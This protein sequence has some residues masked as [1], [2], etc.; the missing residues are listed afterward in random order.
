MTRRSWTPVA[1]LVACVLAAASLVYSS[2]VGPLA[3]ASAATVNLG[4]VQGQMA[5]HVGVD[6]G[7]TGNCI[8]YSPANT[9]SSSGVV[10]S[11]NEAITA[12]GRPG[13]NTST[14]PATLSTSS[15]SSVGF[16]PSSLTSVNDGAPFLIGRMIHYNNPVYAD[17]RYFTG[18]LRSTLTGF[19][20]PNVLTFNWTLDETP[21][22]GGNNCCNDTISFTNQI[23]NVTLSQGGLNFKL[24]ILGFIGT[25]TAATCPATPTG[26]PQNVFS[27]VEG[28]QTHACLY[29]S[30]VQ[31]RSLTIVKNVVGTPPGSPSFAFTSTSA[32]NGS[33]WSSS[34]FSLAGGGSVTRSVTSGDTVTV[35]ETDPGDDRWSLSS[36]VCRQFNAAGQLV[37]IPGSTNAAA[38]KVTL[39]NVPP[40]EFPADPSITCT[41]TNTYTPRSTL[42]LVKQVQGGVVS[43]ALW[44]LT[45]TG[46]TGATQDTV[47]SGPSGSDAVSNKRIVAGAYQLSEQGTGAAETG[48]VQVGNWTCTAGATSFPVTAEG[49][50]TLPDLP[51]GTIVT[52]AVVNRQSTGSLRISKVVDDPLGGYTG[53]T[54]KTFSGTYDCGAGASGTFS[55]LTTA[56]PV[57]I[58]GIPSGRVCSVSE[59][60]PTGGLLNASFAWGAPDYSTQPVTIADQQTA[61]VTVTNRVEQL[62]GAFSV[63]KAVDGPGGYSGGSDRVFPVSYTC[64][65]TNGPTSSGTL[66]VTTAAAVSPGSPIPAGSVCTFSESLTS[67][68]GDFSDPS[69]A[70]TGSSIA[71]ASITVGVDATAAVTVTNTYARETGEL[72]IA[73]VVDG[74]GFI[75]A[76]EPFVVLYDCGVAQGQVTLAAGGSVS[77]T[78]PA[79]TPCTVQEQTP[80]PAL[81]SPAF[82]WGT[83][84]WSPGITAIVPAGG[85]ATLTVTNPTIAVFGAVQVTKSIS[86][87]TAGVTGEASFDVSFSCDNGYTATFPVGVGGTA[88]TADLPVGTTCDVSEAAPSGGL[89]DASYAWGTPDVSPSSVTI[90]AAGQVVPVSIDNPVVRITGALTIAKTL[91]DPDGVVDPART[92][93]I[94]YSCVYGADAPVTGTVSLPPGG[95]QTVSGLLL[96]SSCAVTE[97]DATL[98]ARPSADDA[99][100]V[101]LPAS[102]DPGTSVIVASAA[103]PAEVTVTNTVDRLEGSVRLTKSV[104]GAGKD[105]GYDGGSFTFSVVCT[106]GGVTLLD[107]TPALADGE[108]W[109]P[110][111]AVDL[112]L[113][114]TCAIA[115]TAKPDPT[116]AA[117]G[118]DPV[119]FRIGGALE[120]GIGAEFV[121]DDATIPVQ[122]NATN[123]ITPR[124][125]SVT[126]AKQV[127]G[128]TDG[129]VSDAGFVVNLNC[130]PGLVYQVTVPSNG[131]ATQDGIPVGSTC[132]AVEAPPDPSQLVDASFSWGTPVYV[133]AD[134]T[135]EVPVDGAATV[136]VQNPIERVLVPLRLIKTLSGAQGIIDPSRQY[137]VTWSCTYGGTSFGG[138]V[139]V[140]ADGTGIELAND[141]PVTADCSATEGDAGDPSPDPAFR[142]LDPVIT[143]ATVTA[144]GPNVVTVANTLVRD[145]GT[146]LVRKRV[147]GAIEGYVNL[148]GGDED[149]TLHGSCSVPASP[150]IATR[151]AD[152]VIADGGEV[153]ITAS[154]GWT[155][156]GREDTPSND[157][158]V[159]SSYAW[160]EPVLTWGPISDSEPPAPTPEN[161][162]PFVLTREQPTIAFWAVNPIERVSGA[163]QISKV[164]SD[165]F[166]AVDPDATFTGSYSC[167][168]GT[169]AP[170]T[171]VWSLE[172]GE[173]FT[174]PD[175]LLESVC[176]VTEDDLDAVGLPDPSFEWLPPVVSGPAVVVAGGTATVTVTNTVGRLYAGLDIAKTLQD[177]DGGVLPGAEFTG[178]WTCTL[179]DL[180]L[181]DRFGVAANAT[182]AAFAPADERVPASSTCTLTE[183][184]PDP[185]D[186]VDGSFQWNAPAYDPDEVQLTAGETGLLTV[187]NS[188]S[189]VYSNVRVAKLLSGPGRDLVDPDR[190]FT[191]TVTCV[192]GT[193]DPVVSTWQATPATIWE[194]GGILVGS[195]CTATEDLP[196]AEGQPVEGDPS[197]AW[198]D[199][200]LGG[201]VIVTRTNRALPVAQLA[202][203]IEVTNP[204]RRVFGRFFL[205]KQVAGEV[206]GI[207]DRT[208]SY[209]MTWECVPGTGDPLGGDFALA[210]GQRI[211][212]GP[213]NDPPDEIP[214]GS[215]CTLTEP[216][217]TMPELIDDAWHWNSPQFTVEGLSSEPE[218]VTAPC[219]GTTLP[220]LGA[221]AVVIVVPHPQ[222]NVPDPTIGMEIINTVDQT[223]GAFT[224][225]KTSDPPTGSTIEPG[226]TITYTVTVDSTGTVP[227]H[228]V[229]IT[230]DLTQVLRYGVVAP[231]TAPAGTTATVDE[232]A[233]TLVWTVG[234]LAVGESVTLTYR[235]TVGET[236][237]DATIHNV[238]TAV[239][240]VPPSTCADPF[241]SACTTE[242][243]TPPEPAVPSGPLPP[244]GGTVPLGSLWAGG[245]LLALGAAAVLFTRRRARSRRDPLP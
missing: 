243:A 10:A 80:D 111:D 77:V 191:G 106:L 185:V 51:A 75:G 98:A 192:H 136:Q 13:Q 222:E 73:K 78:V 178:I 85:S 228:D 227:V 139:S 143:G 28:T 14:C 90:T 20:S 124:T 203:P 66:S 135:V 137:P 110:P 87:E 115:E 181:S 104:V 245:L 131:S 183:D 188:V 149:F 47:I 8:R 152:G 30:I 171:G 238:V 95:S 182:V 7:T 221:R 114:T 159:D 5:N 74:E 231:I 179:G 92:F 195:V 214:I 146:V 119:Q 128:L 207:V 32:L 45:A 65:L 16:R 148:G 205:T 209:P 117:F 94:D 48:F 187:S 68:S 50:V 141:V 56:A 63:I 226:E 208:Q 84:V 206:D 116:S 186:L 100:Y 199:P 224:V 24:V 88:S 142:W 173:T 3:S 29:A 81:L 76:G 230:D 147:T 70:W 82:A 151:Y 36:L 163:F 112:P 12:H 99:S 167:V 35:T 212:V 130:G 113:G 122:V 213:E 201:P 153:P 72:I 103:T 166:G 150:D 121:L 67:Q 27:T 232:S 61:T 177:P 197:Y 164:V 154:I 43:P 162:G 144:T 6:N 170:V 156:S 210:E 223:A 97:G 25:G 217:N 60:P 4:T 109:T 165:P 42:T 184:T 129:L 44:T 38:R 234:T 71:P 40:P 89:I 33:P 91:V 225:R 215:I 134:A 236:A 180:V 145:S 240:D 118:W 198:E 175:V 241:D 190:T 1:M 229:V 123:P 41:F 69:F 83:P 17:D 169:D 242:H 237:W 158:L 174:G 219:E 138:T 55:T 34:S 233:S 21:N 140:V 157:L 107:E 23:S 93:D 15:Q 194:Q 105:D 101:W 189:R 218:P 19:A 39:A 239:G 244:T 57:T 18:E 54:S 22:S 58:A 62:F 176:T 9:A 120:A 204:I 102:Y 125:G 202:P 86:G 200:I 196:G 168:Y 52:C 126:L 132:L 96:G 127:T 79:R 133:P 108:S 2:T 59:N 37:T 235:L 53:G 193:D 31:E 216:L 11:P 46:T 155:C 211:V 161:T 49:I 172:A 64:T 220:C 26:T 160:G